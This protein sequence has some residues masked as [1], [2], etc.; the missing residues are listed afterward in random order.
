M[1]VVTVNSDIAAPS[2]NSDP[3]K[4]GLIRRTQPCGT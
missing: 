1:P 3:G 2:P 4:A